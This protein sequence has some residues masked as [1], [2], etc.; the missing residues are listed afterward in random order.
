MADPFI[1]EIRV[2]AGNFAPR[3]WAFCDGQLLP[4]A[5]NTALFS[6]LGTTYGG[7]GR[8]TF[9]LPNLKDRAPLGPRRA[10]GLS[11]YALGESGGEAT[12][13]LVQTQ[14]PAHTHT[15]KAVPD[16]AEVQAPA[17]DRAF[18]RSGPGFA[19]QSNSSTNLVPMANQAL[20]P[21]GGGQAHDNRQPLLVLNYIIALQGIFPPRG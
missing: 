17:P 14:I 18:A 4:L 6:L 9:A 3:G 10:P 20:S 15:V 21:N 16:P 7:D 19:Y 8:T 13:T 12:V 11:L 2:F 1:A 5:Q